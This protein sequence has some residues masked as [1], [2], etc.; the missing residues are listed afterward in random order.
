M[1]RC[2]AI[3]DPTLW[4]N[5]F[6]NVGYFKTAKGPDQ[7][8]GKSTVKTNVPL[9]PKESTISGRPQDTRPPTAVPGKGGTVQ[10]SAPPRASVANI[11]ASGN[12]QATKPADNSRNAPAVAQ[13]AS[14]AAA[15]IEKQSALAQAQRWDISIVNFC[16]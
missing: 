13:P 3:I 7:N 8:A 2:G 16:K 4:C 9:A 10:F 1:P 15:E 11:A 14:N 5:I 6:L 12:T